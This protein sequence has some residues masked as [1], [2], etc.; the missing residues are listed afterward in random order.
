MQT[1]L[2]GPSCTPV[3]E[4]G[5]A[6]RPVRDSHGAR[7]RRIYN[8]LSEYLSRRWHPY[9]PAP[10]EISLLFSILLAVSVG[11]D[12]ITGKKKLVGRADRR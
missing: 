7:W 6:V 3:S 9:L 10:I 8:S 2:T 1:S 12:V 5:R 11:S 4:Q